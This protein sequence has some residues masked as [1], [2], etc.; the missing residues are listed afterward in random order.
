MTYQNVKTSHKTRKLKDI[1]YK[2]YNKISYVICY[3]Q[4]M[5]LHVCQKIIRLRNNTD[6]MYFQNGR[7][8]F[9]Q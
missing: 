7:H 3:L 8:R 1:C 9:V 4:F 6:F 5:F 2:L